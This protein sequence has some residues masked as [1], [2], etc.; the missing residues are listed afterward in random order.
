MDA[1]G[2][3]KVTHVAEPIFAGANGSLKMAQRMP[4]HFWQ[5]FG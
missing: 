2:G 4:A 1:L 5:V 3:G